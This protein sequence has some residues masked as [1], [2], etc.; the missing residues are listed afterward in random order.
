M[1]FDRLS[2]RTARQAGVGILALLTLPCFGQQPM[3]KREA[4]RTKEVVVESPANKIVRE[5]ASVPGTGPRIPDG[6]KRAIEA[7]AKTAV[8][9]TAPAESGRAAT[10]PEANPTVK[11]G[12]VRWH[13]SF[14]EACVAAKKSGKPVL[15]F[16]MM[17]QLDKQFC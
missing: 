14:A 10:G 3:G 8:A 7:S 15:L 17:G 5:S 4:D 6:G 9:A 16:H 12:E 1:P 2:I 11:P 13:Q